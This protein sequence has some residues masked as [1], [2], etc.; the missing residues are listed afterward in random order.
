MQDSF[1]LTDTDKIELSFSALR[2]QQP[3][4]D[5]FIASVPYKILCNIA[6]FDVRRVLQEER[7]IERYLGIQRP[8]NDARVKELEKYV[9]FYDASFPTSIILAIEDEYVTYNDDSKQLTVRN[10]K[11]NDEKPTALIRKIAK[12]L[13]GQHR[14]AGLFK[15]NGDTFDVPVSIF[16]GSDISDQAYIFATVNLEQ[17]KVSKSLAYDLFSLARTRSPQRT[18]HQ[19]AVALDGDDSSP[20]YKRIKR[21][22]IATPGRTRELLTQATFVESLMQYISRDP[23]FDRD[24]LLKG[25]KLQRTYDRRTIFR[26]MFIDERDISI[27]QIVYNFFSAV[28]DRWPLAWDSPD[29]GA[30][31][32]KTNGFRALMRILSPVYSKIALPG[33]VPSKEKFYDIFDR[34]KVDD[35]HFNTDNYQ[36]GTSGEA[37]LRKDFMLWLELEEI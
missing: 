20:F 5:L 4:G 11:E 16:V 13:D 31:L 18:C 19:I 25:G 21:L 23:K 22:G 30:V 32:N 14:I 12:V 3:I 37:E 6:F 7:D 36:P 27:A 29:R 8:L 26:D 24:V 2:A 33:N 10:F 34:A 1:D 28:R 17:N 15:F 9:N 35:H